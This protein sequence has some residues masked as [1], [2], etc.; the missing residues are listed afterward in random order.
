MKTLV[1][2]A[3]IQNLVQDLNKEFDIVKEGITIVETNADNRLNK[4]E[5][6]VKQVLKKDYVDKK[7]ATLKE[8]TDNKITDLNQKISDESKNVEEKFKNVETELGKQKD[9]VTETQAEAL[10]SDVNK[11]FDRVHEELKAIKELKSDISNI[12]KNSATRKQLEEQ[13]KDIF[14]RLDQLR[15][16]TVSEKE[17]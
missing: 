3:Q 6:E 14:S 2:T 8:A 13:S 5:E 11:E 16:E 17:Y 15:K 9:F 7:I 12:E 1:K 10:V 4:V